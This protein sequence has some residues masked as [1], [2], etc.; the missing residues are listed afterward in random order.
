MLLTQITN[1]WGTA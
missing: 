1:Q